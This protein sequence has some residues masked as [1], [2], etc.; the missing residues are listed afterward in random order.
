MRSLLLA[1]L[2]ALCAIPAC[3]KKAV[4]APPST[5]SGETSKAGSFLAYEHTIRIRVPSGEIASRVAAVRE[6]CA[7]S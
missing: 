7:T 6:A 3:S 4:T 1:L 5:A 2:V